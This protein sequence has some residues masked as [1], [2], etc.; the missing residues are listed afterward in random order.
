VHAHK[1]STADILLQGSDSAVHL[2]HSLPVPGLTFPATV[3]YGTIVR[4][5]RN[6]PVLMTGLCCRVMYMIWGWS[7]TVLMAAQ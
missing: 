4:V 5:E 7:I 2:C 6:M 1:N 3:E